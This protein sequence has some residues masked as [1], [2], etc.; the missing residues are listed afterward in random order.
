MDTNTFTFLDNLGNSDITISASSILKL[1]LV[2][3][4]FGNLF[5]A[6]MLY[7]RSR[8]LADTLKS[9]QNTFLKIVI[10]IYLLASLLGSIL[11]VI[12]LLIG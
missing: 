10:P 1:P 6:A 5:F 4:I 2:I 3:L 11:A 8:I 9:N 12:F 7:F